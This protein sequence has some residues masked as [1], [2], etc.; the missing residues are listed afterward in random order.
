[1]PK[2]FVDPIADLRRAQLPFLLELEREQRFVHADRA[3]RRVIVFETT[4]K[5]FV[6][7]AAIADA[8]ARHLRQGRRDF[9]RGTISV[10]SQSFKLL[11]RE[12]WTKTRATRS[13]FEVRRNDRG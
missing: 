13:S 9:A 12:C 10:A 6:A 4:V 3:V 1:M 5:A 7:H 8:I 2:R 11:R